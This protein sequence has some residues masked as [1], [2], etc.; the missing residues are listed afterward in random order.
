MPISG[1]YKAP[2]TIMCL[3][4]MCSAV[5]HFQYTDGDSCNYI[6]VLS[7]NHHHGLIQLSWWTHTTTIVDS[8]NYHHLL[9]YM[10]G[11]SRNYCTFMS[12][13]TTTIMDSYNYHRG[14]IQLSSWTHTTTIICFDT[15]MEIHATTF[16]CFH[17]TTIMDSYNYHQVL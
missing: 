8:Y 17:T 2:N 13:H 10:D 3:L 15:W 1:T 12:F 7:Y 4:L 6:Y 5:I 14:L 16:M 9:W 11:N